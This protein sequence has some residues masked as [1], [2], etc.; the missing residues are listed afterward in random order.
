MSVDV[1]TAEIQF[2]FGAGSCKSKSSS[3]LADEGRYWIDNE[4]DCN[5]E[6]RGSDFHKMH[7]QL[8][9]IWQ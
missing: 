4:R 9:F 2:E 5:Y 6:I 3:C 7:A 1:H 8:K